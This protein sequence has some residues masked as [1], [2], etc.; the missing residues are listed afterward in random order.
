MKTLSSS[1]FT[2]EFSAEFE[3]ER[4]AWLRRRFL[5]YVGF[6]LVTNAVAAA[7][8]IFAWSRGGMQ[9]ATTP[10]TAIK[11]LMLGLVGAAVTL[12]LYGAG[13][14]YVWHRRNGPAWPPTRIAFWLIVLTG[15][16]SLLTTPMITNELVSQP[17]RSAAAAPIVIDPTPIGG[18]ADRAEVGVALAGAVQPAASEHPDGRPSGDKRK[19]ANQTAVA[20]FAAVWG[21][22]ITHVLA[23]LFLPWTP[24]ESFRPLMPLIAATALVMIAFSVRAAVAGA[25]SGALVAIAAGVVASSMVIGLPG[26]GVCWWRHARF[27]RRFTF[28]VMRGRYVELRQELTNARQ[29]H[30]SLFPAPFHRDGLRFRYLY[31]PMRQIGGDYLYI[32]FDD[33]R[34][35]PRPCNLVLTD[36]TGHGIPA[37]LTV[38]RLHGELERIFAE[39]PGCPPGKVLA[40]LNRYV[41]LTLANHSV[42]ATALCLRFDPARDTLEYASGG[43]PPAFL[44]GADGSIDRLD[45]TTLVLGAEVGADFEPDTRALRF[46]PGDTLIA[47]TDGALEARDAA[48]RYFGIVGLERLLAASTPDAEHGWPR[49]VLR[50][51]D[52]HRYGPIA[53]DTLV[54]EITRDLPAPS[55]SGEGRGGVGV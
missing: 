43:H 40:L 32:R 8:A 21:I 5:W 9:S 14:Y 30:E 36:V 17:R 27:H 54:V 39:N 25:G 45:C 7:W 10:A 16:F 51:V 2:S 24:R 23:C 38:N 13:F 34:A 18:A 12:G 46:M 3:A 31:E 20:G 41:H 15:L 35:G 26:A 19:S 42:Y 52:A 53:D 37:A 6:V 28:D 44:R 49:A 55:S 50:A 4:Q 33:A 29:I 1:P 11:A 48:G 22:F 47:Y